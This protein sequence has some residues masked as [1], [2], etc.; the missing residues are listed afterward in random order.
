MNI[1][2][3]PTNLIIGVL[4]T[5]IFALA[6]SLRVCLPY[7][8][9]FGSGWIKFTGIDAYFQMRIVDNLVHNFPHLLTL[10]LCRSEIP[11]RFCSPLSPKNWEYP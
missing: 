9:V 2:K 11:H 3:L 5:M 1:S 10:V 8:Q 7:D 6:L 4:V